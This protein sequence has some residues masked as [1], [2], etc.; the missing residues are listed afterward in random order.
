MLGLGVFPGGA[1][2]N[3]LQIFGSVA[4]PFFKKNTIIRLFYNSGTVVIE[5]RSIFA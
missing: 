3:L 2:T 1:E 5:C 4:F